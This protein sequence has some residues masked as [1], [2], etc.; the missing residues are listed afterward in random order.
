MI[1]GGKQMERLLRYNLQYFAEGGEKT[2]EATSK[3]LSDARNEGQVA[4]STDLVTAAALL[5][6]L[7][8]IRISLPV[9]ISAFAVALVTNLLQVKWKITSKP[10]QPKF[11]KFNPIKGFKKIF[12]K[13]KIL[14]LVKEVIKIGVIIYVAYDTLKKN[15][16]IL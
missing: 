7:A 3:K 13:D 16:N 10:L 6:S 8:I 4:K 5:N 15:E 14:E 2:E 9:F 1:T 11:S 12:S